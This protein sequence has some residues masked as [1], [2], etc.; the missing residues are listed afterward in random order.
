MWSNIGRKISGHQ[1]IQFL[2][3]NL[4]FFFKNYNIKN[5]CNYKNSIYFPVVP[6]VMA[7]PNCIEIFDARSPVACKYPISEQEFTT[8]PFRTK[9]PSLIHCVRIIWF[10]PHVKVQ[11]I[12]SKKVIQAKLIAI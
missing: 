12:A 3:R 10:F 1:G 9:Y 8:K 11:A 6:L 7:F 4:I 2:M 5:C